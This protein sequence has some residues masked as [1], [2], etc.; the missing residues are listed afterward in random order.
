VNATDT[1]TNTPTI[2]F[3][4]TMT[5]TFT[6]T[7]TS[8]TQGSLQPVYSFDNTLECWTTKE[9]YGEITGTTL[10][11]SS[12]SSYSGTGCL[13]AL[14]PFTAPSQFIQLQNAFVT[15][16]DLTG[17]AMRCWVK[18]SSQVMGSGT[19]TVHL[20][21]QTT[22]NWTWEQGSDVIIPNSAHDTW[23]SIGWSPTYSGNSTNVVCIGL[24]VYAGG[25]GSPTTGGVYLD[26]FEVYDTVPTSTPTITP[27]PGGALGWH[28]DSSSEVGLAAWSIDLNGG[29]TAA[30]TA[31]SLSAWDGTVDV[32]N[33]SSSGSA[34]IYV[35]FT[36]ISQQLLV[37]D[38][39]GSSGTT[40]NLTGKAVTVK[41]R[42]DSC[43][44]ADLASSPIIAQ[45]VLKSGS[46]WV[47]GAGSWVNLTATGT[48]FT[49]TI[50]SVSALTST[51]P[52]FDPTQ[53]IQAAVAF[54]TG[55]AGT[56]GATVLHIDDWL[57]Q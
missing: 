24:Q 55:S 27:T 43:V 42:V 18:V 30:V 32:N 33:S 48:W 15:P 10:S 29:S 7:A 49:L 4:S 26:Q 51:Y 8:C 31:G 35:P 12:V 28:F 53:V 56:Y 6:V 20:F 1:V 2:T 50:P 34:S 47:Y 40:L 37:A 52:T 16:S 11:I 39:V 36:T 41:V 14:A 21:D 54:Q 44:G 17:K 3:T 25:A 38:S 13:E 22:S 45:V 5:P 23:V 46:G 57:Y 19:C 9:G